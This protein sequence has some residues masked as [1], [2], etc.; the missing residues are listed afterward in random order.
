[1]ESRQLDSFSGIVKEIKKNEFRDL[2]KLISD[3]ELLIDNFDQSETSYLEYLN[4]QLREL[5][6]EARLLKDI[7]ERLVENLEFFLN[8]D[9]DD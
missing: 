2:Q 3:L 4:D 5:K 8:S 1:M 9:D 7:K 6:E